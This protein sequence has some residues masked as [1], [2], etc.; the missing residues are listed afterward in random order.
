MT[1]STAYG[2]TVIESTEI[3]M[4]LRWREGVLQQAFRI[5]QYVD[6]L[7]GPPRLDWRPVPVVPS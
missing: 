3:T 6:G 1:V 7:P 5:T 4:Q 2:L